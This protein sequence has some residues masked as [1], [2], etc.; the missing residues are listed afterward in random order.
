MKKI[1]S[2]VVV[3]SMLLSSLGYAKEKKPKIERYLGI[4][5]VMT[6]IKNGDRSKHYALINGKERL[7]DLNG[8][9]SFDAVYDLVNVNRSPRKYKI[10]KVET[11]ESSQF[12]FGTNVYNGYVYDKRYKNDYFTGQENFMDDV[13]EFVIRYN[14]HSPSSISFSN[15]KMIDRGVQTSIVAKLDKSKALPYVEN[16]AM[17]KDYIINYL[18]KLLGGNNMDADSKSIID[19]YLKIDSKDL[20]KHEGYLYI[21]PYVITLEKIPSEKDLAVIDIFTEAKYPSSKKIQVPILVHNLSDEEVITTV[22]FND[23][24][25]KYV[26]LLPEETKIV[27]FEYLTPDESKTVEFKAEINPKREIKEITYDNNIKTKTAEI[28]KYEKEKAPCKSSVQWTEKDF[29]LE[30]KSYTYTYSCTRP[31]GQK[32]TCT[33]T[34]TIQV[35]VWYDFVYQADIKTDIDIFDRKGEQKNK[36][37]IKSGYGVMLKTKSEITVTQVSGKWAREPR[38]KPTDATSATAT[39]SY[40]VDTIMKQPSVLNLDRVGKNEFK[41]G[42]NPASKTGAKVI[43]TDIDLKDG[44]YELVV[45]V[46]GARV[47]GKELCS[48]DTVKFKIKGNLHE[49]SYIRPTDSNKS[50]NNN[51]FSGTFTED[52]RPK[53]DNGFN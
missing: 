10:L 22:K 5:R 29:R 3:L 50:K 8:T 33:G 20:N 52:D 26:K 46:K 28:T 53:W 41:T 6:Y 34:Q 17:D 15:Y 36:V 4:T 14:V 13:Y 19:R 43:Y 24:K 7:I 45:R 35:P 38:Q 39:T 27:T 21:I 47:D 31:S 42:V 1:L 11:Y 23:T 12:G 25:E 32:G 49:D 48:V 2:F 16:S 51:T 30:N 18:A 40:K 37:V 44:E 9:L